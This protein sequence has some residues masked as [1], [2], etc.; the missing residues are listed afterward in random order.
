MA[1]AAEASVVSPVVPVEAEVRLTVCSSWSRP[2]ATAWLAAEAELADNRLE[3]SAALV[4][5]VIPA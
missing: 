3:N 2:S 5:R 4:A 1:V